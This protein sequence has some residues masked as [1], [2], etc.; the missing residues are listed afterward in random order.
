MWNEVDPR[1][2]YTVHSA[3]RSFRHELLVLNFQGIPVL[4]QHGS[5]DDNVPA[6]HSRRLNQLAFQS[7]QDT[8]CK[9][10]ELE[11]KGHWYSGVMTTSPL[12]K[13]YS[14]LLDTGAQIPTMPQCFSIV[15]ANPADM[16]PRGNVMVDQLCTHDQ[17]GKVDIV[18][19]PLS[20]VWVMSTSNIRR[21]HFVPREDGGNTHPIVI[22]DGYMVRIRHEDPEL[23][24]W[25][26]RV[27]DG[28]WT[29]SHL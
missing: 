28:S 7:S 2:M 15:V 21:F 1:I 11:G 16:G 18:R 8:S 9:Y 26:V 5:A 29:V 25:Y 14:D 17:L 10:V 19:D 24:C 20:M 6:L 23:L 22:I 12:C 3:L 4:Q 13:F 27:G